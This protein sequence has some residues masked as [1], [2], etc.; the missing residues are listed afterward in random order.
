SKHG[1][2]IV[3]HSMRRYSNPDSCADSSRAAATRS[4]EEFPTNAEN[5]S[6]S[7]VD[8]AGKI[9]PAPVVGVAKF[10]E[11][12]KADQLELD[13][14]FVERRSVE[15]YRLSPRIYSTDPTAPGF[16]CQPDFDIESAAPERPPKL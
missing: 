14:R 16:H 1:A 15:R 2:K 5:L 7:G 11:K 4:V 13:V 12:I 6:V 10:I 3:A 9:N 8:Q